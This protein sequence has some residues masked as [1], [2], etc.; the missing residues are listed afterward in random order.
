MRHIHLKA[1][2][3]QSSHDVMSREND[4]EDSKETFFELFEACLYPR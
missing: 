4:I 3:R 1:H 2:R